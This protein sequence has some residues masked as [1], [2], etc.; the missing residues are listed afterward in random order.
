MIVLRSWLW[1][2]SDVVVKILW[3]E[4]RRMTLGVLDFPKVEV[5]LV[6]WEQESEET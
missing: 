1:E 2:L 3:K 5:L 6:D 4:Q